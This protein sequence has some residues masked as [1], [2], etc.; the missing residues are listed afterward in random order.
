MSTRISIFLVSALLAI[1]AAARETLTGRVDSVADGDTLTLVMSGGKKAKIRFQGIDA[2]ETTQAHGKRAK[3]VLA[4]MVQGR[5]VRVEVEET[6]RYGRKVAYIF[7]GLKNINVEMVRQG[8]A[9]HYVQYAP[10]NSELRSAEAEAKAAKRGLW[11]DKK[12]PQAPWDYR[13]EK[14]KK[15]TWIWPDHRPVV[16]KAAPF[17]AA[18]LFRWA[19]AN[20]REHRFCC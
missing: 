14:R 19:S 8:L 9:W 3:E 11:A 6:D 10:N 20:F 4:G 18:F 5:T 7:V 2:P 13:K 15:T 12:P 17:G 1:S 16:T